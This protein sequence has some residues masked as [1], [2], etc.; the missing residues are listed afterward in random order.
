MT[1]NMELESRKKHN[2]D[3]Y[4]TSWHMDLSAP[5][6]P[7]SCHQSDCCPGGFQIKEK[8]LN[9]LG[10]FGVTWVTVTV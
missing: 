6:R 5:T 4:A 9:S 8:A 2:V 7:T 10:P 1:Q 3:P